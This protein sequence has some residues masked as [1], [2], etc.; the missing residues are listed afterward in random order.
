MGDESAIE[1]LTRVN[2]GVSLLL[3][4]LLAAAWLSSGSQLAMAQ[5]ADA[6]TD[7]FVT[8][9]L[10]WAI[11]YARRPP[12]DTHP[13]G[14]QGAEPLAALLA[15]A[16][17]AVLSVEVVSSAIDTLSREQTAKLGP[18]VAAIFATRV[19]LRGAVLAAATVLR[20]RSRS[21]ALSALLVDAR[22]D[23]LV[24]LLALVGF[25]AARYGH[26][27]LDAWLALP[28]GVWVGL[29]GLGLAGEN[30]GLLL[31]EAPEPERREAWRKCA[32][33]IEG[34]VAVSRLRARSQGQAY[35]VQVDVTVAPD[36]D[37]GTAFEIGES[38][39]VQLE[40]EAD[41]ADAMARVRPH[42]EG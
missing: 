9:A 26:P 41:V 10:L 2:L 21:P 27:T 20:R 24:S 42:A 5:G 15:A 18:A 6:L 25:F 17:A 14:H 1:R 16:V 37:V 36:L 7:T 8:I 23:V 32:A 19:L 3:C 4:V 22:N 30:V 39:R 31:G 11:G 34:V 29:S 13:F 40:S 33:Q 28:L 12:D 38:V 35:F